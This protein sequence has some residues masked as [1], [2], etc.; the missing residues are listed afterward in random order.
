[1]DDVIVTAGGFSLSLTGA[2]GKAVTVL[3]WVKGCTDV[4]AILWPARQLLIGSL[5]VPERIIH[6]IGLLFDR[7]PYQ[8][9]DGIRPNPFRAGVEDPL[10]GL[11]ANLAETQ[12]QGFLLR[13]D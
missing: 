5:I 6:Q 10:F 1:M 13:A 7:D 3:E 11:A 2:P 9:F 12:N 8:L 4:T